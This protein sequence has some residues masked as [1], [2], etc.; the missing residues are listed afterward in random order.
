MPPG[1]EFAYT[2]SNY[3]LLGL[4][5]EK[6][7][8]TTYADALRR[9]LLHQP[10]RWRI[11]IQDREAPTAPISAPAPDAETLP[12]DPYLPT[13]ALASAAGAAGGIAADA[14]SVARWGYDLYGARLLP[15]DAVHHMTTAGSDGYGLGTEV[16]PLS[17]LPWTG[18]GHTGG[19]PGYSTALIVV[20]EHQTTV[21]VLLPHQSDAHYIAR[22]LLMALL[23]E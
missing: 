9:D 7:T 22:M 18:I 19:I 8:T 15:P 4:L 20:P 2:N 12:G 13:R 5:I 3:L 11:A 23:P 21:C 1:T 10:N 6:V 17:N 16:A 14:E